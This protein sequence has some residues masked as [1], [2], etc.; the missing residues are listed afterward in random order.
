LTGRSRIPRCCR[1]AGLARALENW[2]DQV[3]EERVWRAIVA[4]VPLVLGDE[5]E[6]WVFEETRTRARGPWHVLK[7]RQQEFLEELQPYLAQVDEMFDRRQWILDAPSLADYGVY[8]GY[9]L[10]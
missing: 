10:G 2:G 3:L 4:E 7:A 5:R 1:R 9:L 8:G 6:R